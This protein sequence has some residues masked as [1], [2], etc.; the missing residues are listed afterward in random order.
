MW[1]LTL[2]I[3]RYAP[4]GLRRWLFRSV[5]QRF[6]GSLNFIVSGGA[7]LEP[8]LGTRWHLLGVRVIQGYGATEASPVIS[9]HR[10]KKPRF[11]SAGLPLPG[12]EVRIAEDGE[13]LVRGPNIVPG[14]WEAPEQTAATFQNGWYITGDLGFIDQQGFLHIRGR[15]KDMIAMPDGQK[16]YPDD[17]EA[18]LRRHPAVTDAVVVGLPKGSGVEVH[19]ALLLQD[20]AAAPQVVSWANIQLEDRQQVRGFTVWPEEDFP[21]THTLKVK[22]AA[23]LDT[24][25]GV[26]PMASATLQTSVTQPVGAWQASPAHGVSTPRDLRRIVA[27]VSTLPLEQMT[28][29]KTLG[30]DLNLDSLKRV[31]LLSA[32]EEELGVYVDETQ[33]G[34]G[35]TVHQLEE[36]VEQ[37]SRTG[38]AKNFVRWGMSWWCRPLRGILQR[39][40]LFPLVFL[41]YRLRVVGKEN[42]SGIQGPVLFVANHSLHTD[43]G[44]IIKAIP[45]RWRRQ[46]A[47]AAA[48]DLWTRPFTGPFWG[49]VNPLLGNGF[50]FSREGAIRSSL[51]NLG[52]VLDRGWSVL[53]YPEGKMTIGGPMQPFKSGIGLVAVESRIQVIPLRLHIHYMGVPWQFPI[54]RRGNIE[55]SFGRPLSYPPGTS[56]LEAA[57]A[58]E[59]AVKA[60]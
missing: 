19:A 59:E 51:D 43:N 29:D 10:L 20:Q 53:I 11:D 60:L 49:V 33:V 2:K 50:P 35:T 18:V 1:H 16:V 26:A 45:W 14:Y 24:L 27:E 52:A 22:K 48:A 56:Y 47:I 28:P 7:A 39:A 31:E 5:H 55:V 30:G 46:L 44:L 12:V 9:C 37:G 42:L 23:V 21:R 4:L 17:I 6:G 54:L 36:M 57:Q 13:I 41:T 25:T 8:E 58:I 3:A 34:P 40:M 15:K 32:V 38:D